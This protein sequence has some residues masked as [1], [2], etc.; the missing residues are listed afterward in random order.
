MRSDFE[1]SAHD[2]LELCFR[3]LKFDNAAQISDISKAY[4]EK[5]KA[6]KEGKK[7][8]EET[9]K[10][11]KDLKKYPKGF[12]NTLPYSRMTAAEERELMKRYQ[13]REMIW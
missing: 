10:F 3:L 13:T 4:I 9:Q 12:Q 6:A 1:L 2:E 11:L 8:S 7:P 5:Y